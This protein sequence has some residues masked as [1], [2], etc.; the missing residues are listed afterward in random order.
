[1]YSYGIVAANKLLSSKEIQVTPMEQLPMTNGELTDNLTSTNNKGTD[2]DGASFETTVHQSATLT[3]RWLPFSSNRKTAPDVRRGEKVCIWKFA[4]A[5]KY[6]WSE[7]EYEE[8][9][10]KLE[11]VIFG[12]SGT[13]DE[14]ATPGED[15]TY[16]LEISTHTKQ[17]RFHT[18]QADGEPYGY[19]I[20]I[21]T[22][23]GLLQFLD[24]I[25]NVFHWDSGAKRMLLKNADGTFINLD[26][27]D[28]LI[29]VEGDF[30][31]NVKGKY[32]LIVEG[33]Y[34]TKAAKATFVTP[35]LITT[36]IFQ[37]GSNAI[38]GGSLAIA[39]GMTTGAAD[40]SGG[41]IVLNGK[42]RATGDAVFEGDVT[43]PVFHGHLDGT[44]ND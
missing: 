38:V 43:A 14:N 28:L 4:D 31:T 15:N 17:V 32:N 8:K 21:N 33:E 10:R 37:S 29:N 42:I 3:A 13:Q 20:S 40:G 27:K 23:D 41:D 7:C 11:T 1:M 24:T 22:K 30:T 19:D 25:E 39:Q 9:F 5:D 26:G 16:F 2:A 35:Q 18:S 12:F 6:Y 34:A 44:D 36:E